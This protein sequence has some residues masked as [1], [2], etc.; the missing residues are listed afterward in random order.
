V[1]IAESTGN[2]LKS[3]IQTLVCPVNV[4]GVMGAGLAMEF[5]LQYPAM[6]EAYRRF[7]WAG[8][9]ERKGIFVYTVSPTRKILCL[10]TKRHWKYRS[11]IEWVDQAL[12][13]IASDYEKY[14]ITELAIPAVGCG[15][16]KLEWEDVYSLIKNHMNRIPLDVTVYLP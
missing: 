3:D 12:A 2:I 4:V 15:K 13:T 7:C 5:K 10:P 16:G 14:G 9:F 8:L 6:Y 1:I 11:K